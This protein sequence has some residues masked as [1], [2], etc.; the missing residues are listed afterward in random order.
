[1]NDKIKT[2]L[3]AAMLLCSVTLIAVGI[4]GDFGNFGN[5]HITATLSPAQVTYKANKKAAEKATAAI[6]T[7]DEGKKAVYILNTGSKVFHHPWCSFSDRINEENFE[8]VSGTR[9]EMLQN[10]FKSCGKC[11]P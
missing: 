1:M 5:G 7:A 9:T 8:T 2:A 10:G 6:V 11:N 3:I 4:F